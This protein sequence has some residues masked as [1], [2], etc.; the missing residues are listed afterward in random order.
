MDVPLLRTSMKIFARILNAR[1]TTG[2]CIQ[3]ETLQVYSQA[4]CVKFLNNT[5]STCSFSTAQ[6]TDNKMNFTNNK[7]ISWRWSLVPFIFTT[8]LFWVGHRQNEKATICRFCRI[9]CRFLGTDKKLLKSIGKATTCRFFVAFFVGFFE[10]FRSTYGFQLLEFS[11][12]KK[13]LYFKVTRALILGGL[14]IYKP[15]NTK[16]W[17]KADNSRQFNPNFFRKIFFLH[18]KN[19]K[20]ATEKATKKRQFTDKSPTK[21]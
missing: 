19:D 16:F 17:R 4:G 14:S 9:F 3:P 8:F 5:Y 15:T 12:K 6:Q 10:F 20:K 13:L 18:Q 21:K 11:F 1:T 2:S 7:I